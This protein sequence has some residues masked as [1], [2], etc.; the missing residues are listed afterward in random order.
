MA[1]P[2]TGWVDV[3]WRDRSQILGKQGWRRRTEKGEEW[4]RL[5]RDARTQKGLWRHRWL[6][7]WIDVPNQIRCLC[8]QCGEI[9]ECES[10]I[11]AAS[12][13]DVLIYVQNLGKYVE[14]VMAYLEI[15][16][17][18]QNFWSFRIGDLR[19]EIQAR[20]HLNLNQEYCPL[21]GKHCYEHKLTQ[22]SAV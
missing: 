18:R 21:D 10:L 16:S 6:D 17:H 13:S 14:E 1:K 2:R 3:I 9:N 8:L 11:N 20:D 5:L 4:R 12:G 15:R 22:A 19:A 7:G